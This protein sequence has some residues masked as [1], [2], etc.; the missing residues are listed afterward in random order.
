L[1]EHALLKA[2][3]EHDVLLLKL[4]AP[5]RKAHA[6]PDPSALIRPY[7]GKTIT[8]VGNRG[9]KRSSEAP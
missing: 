2:L 9:P 6:G 1:Q 3:R 5:L 4:A 8:A 7:R